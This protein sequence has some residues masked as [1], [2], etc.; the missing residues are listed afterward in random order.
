MRRFATWTTGHRKTVILGWIVALIGIGMIAGSVGSDFTEEFKL[1]SSDSQEAFDLLE[2]RFPQQSGVTAEIVYKAPAG[3]DSPA[4]RKK[5]EGVFA[6]AAKLPHVSEVASPYVSGGAAAISKD[7]E[8]A[9]ATVQYDTTTDKLEKDDIKKLVAIGRAANGEGLQVE[10]GGAPIEEVRSE[11]EGDSSF[12]IGLLAAVVILLL[13][14]GSV[15]AMGLPLLT[16]LFALGVGLSLVTLGTHVFDTAEFA[17]QLAAMI[18]LGVGIDYALFIL[19]RFRNGLDEGLEPR[20]AAIAA[21]DTAGRAVLFAGVTVII[22]L[23]GMLLLGISFLYGVA[24][25]AATA[26][27]CSR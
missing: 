15:V 11:E 13:T 27:S 5:M 19:T 7:G 10:V 17:P 21:V 3:A 9:Y 14:F 6:E 2:E 23:M 12:A 16:A 8:I 25:A 24:M 20:P 26:R 22:S 1:P 18:G 4:V